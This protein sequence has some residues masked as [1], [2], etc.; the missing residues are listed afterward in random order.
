MFTRLATCWVCATMCIFASAAT[1]PAGTVLPQGSNLE[2]RLQTATGSRISHSGD[3]VKAVVI[4]P[5]FD[6]DRLIIPQGS[7]I[8][9]I[10]NAVDRLGLGIVHRTARIS[11][12][13]DSLEFPNGSRISLNARTAEVETAR[14]RVG[15]G[16][17]IRG[18]NPNV[19]LSSGAS[20]L[21]SALMADVQFAVPALGVKFLIARSPDPEIYFPAGTELILEMTADASIASFSDSNFVPPIRKEDGLVVEKLLAALPAQQTIL[22]RNRPS[23]LVNVLLLGTH[24]QIERAFR[25]AGW[26]GEA[27]RSAL[28]LYRM[29]HC[30]VQRTGYSMAPMAKLR[31]DGHLPDDVYQKSLDTFAKRHHIRLWQQPGS[32]AWVGATTQDVSFTI[33]RMHV[34]HASEVEIDNERAKVLNDLWLTGCVDT[35]SLVSRESLRRS[36]GQGSPL[37]TDGSI[38]V[39][40]MNDCEVP[41]FASQARKRL[42]RL[43]ASQML[44]AVGNDLAHSN[45]ITLGYSAVK[46]ILA[47]PNIQTNSFQNSSSSDRKKLSFTANLPTQKWK[48]PSVVDAQVNA[49]PP[50]IFPTLTAKRLR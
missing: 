19:S 27:R 11:Y 35:A 33:K 8:S 36:A 47:N 48:R 39:L 49:P 28:A 9:G 45:P 2:V 7:T 29:Y 24:T 25:A 16:G 1:L 10:V 17:E 13:F 46:T 12:R 15:S 31:L 30:F 21:I 44:V 5:V 22:G 26:S 40:R 23:D 50:D 37:E 34:T 32:D 42:P 14:E 18:I 20:I 3:P 43:S 41:R 4:A 38:A 6:D